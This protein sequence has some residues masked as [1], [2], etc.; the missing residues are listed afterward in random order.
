MVEGMASMKWRVRWM[1]GLMDVTR[2]MGKGMVRLIR[3]VC[4]MV[5][6][7]W[8]AE[9]KA[10]VHLLDP[11]GVTNGKVVRGDGIICCTA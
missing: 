8:M 6:S 5:S 11:V 7:N 2:W 10:R 4:W 3:M 1:V 9:M